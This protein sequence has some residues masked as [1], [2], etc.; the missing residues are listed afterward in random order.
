MSKISVYIIAYNE[1]EKVS[2]TIESVPWADEIVLVDSWSTDGT[3]EIAAKLG[4]RVVQ[5]DF[6]GFGDLRNQAIAA[7]SHEWIFSLDADE[8][9]TPEVENEIRAI[10]QDPAA[11]DA[12]WVPRRN[13]F[14]GRWI[15]HSGWYPNYRQPQLFRKGRMQYDLKPVHEGYVLDSTHPIGHLKNAIWQFPFKNM[16]EVMHKANRYSSLGAEKI[17]HKKISMGSALAHGLWSFVK[18]YVFK[19]GFL[20]GW[21]GFVIALG[22]FEGTFYRYVKAL[23]MQKGQ[24]WQVPKT[25]KVPR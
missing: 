1:A 13:F 14:M 21:A 11:V 6:K 9:C 17:V 10:T 20:D 22:N 8:R 4:A 5:V 12:Y 25:L 7:C 2:A 19:L 3:P 23:E 15:K 16:S 24:T 18:H